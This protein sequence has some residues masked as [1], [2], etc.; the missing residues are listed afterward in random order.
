M[1]VGEWVFGLVQ[2]GLTLVVIFLAWRTVSVASETLREARREQRLARLERARAVVG[3]IERL[4]RWGGIAPEKELNKERLAT[5]VR[6]SGGP[7][8]LPETAK[9]ASWHPSFKGA[10]ELMEAA[11]LE[12]D[13][14][15]DESFDAG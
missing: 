8:R 10:E 9:L 7:K 6:S 1:S 14:A 2:T 12:L 15:I 3:E 13:E 5:L 4:N 11:R